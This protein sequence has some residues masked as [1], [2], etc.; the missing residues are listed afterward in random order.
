PPPEF[1]WFKHFYR[2]RFE[3][4]EGRVAVRLLRTPCEVADQRLALG[5]G[6]A[7]IQA[8]DA[9]RGTRWMEPARL[10]DLASA[11][12]R[13]GQPDRARAA[14]VDL[15]RAAPGLF[16]GLVTLAARPD[17]EAWRQEWAT[18]VGRGR[19]TWYGHTFREQAEAS[20]APIGTVIEDDT[21]GGGQFLRAAPDGTRAGGLKGWLP[22]HFLPGPDR[23]TV[24]PPP[25][26]ARAVPRARAARRRRPDR[27]AGRPPEPP[28]ARR[29]RD[30]HAGL[31]AGPR[32]GRLGGGRPAVR[33][34]PGAGG[35]RAPG[36]LPRPRHA[37]HG[38]G[39]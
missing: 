31:D 25:P 28:G 38:R 30:R 26:V 39:D 29:R 32:G 13:A 14:L 22:Q 3:P 2:L 37:R 5:E 33:D 21:A 36:P 9:C 1:P 10:F 17:G 8:L 11:S 4:G 34:G 16:Q 27:A 12:G 6:S 35:P 18:L 19:F 20:P 24:R 15:E 7:A 23:A